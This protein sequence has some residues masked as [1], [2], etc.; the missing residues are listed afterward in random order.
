MLDRKKRGLAIPGQPPRKLNGLAF[1]LTLQAPARMPIRCRQLGIARFP[2]HG[3]V[4]NVLVT[5]LTTQS[6]F[7]A[8]IPFSPAQ[9]ATVRDIGS[10]LHLGET[11][12]ALKSGEI[13]GSHSD[14][15]AKENNNDGKQSCGP[16]ASATE[17]RQRQ[18]RTQAAA[19][20]AGSFCGN[21]R[22][23]YQ[24][25]VGATRKQYPGTICRAEA[26]GLWLVVPAYPLGRPGPQVIFI[27]AIPDEKRARIVSWAFWRNFKFCAWIGPRHTNYP[28]GSVCA[29]PPNQG[30][31]G[32]GD[33]FVHYLDRSCEWC[34]RHIHLWSEKYWP[35][36]QSGMGPHYQLAEG[37]PQELCFCRS[38]KEYYA[39][40]RNEDAVNACDRSRDN[41][42]TLT[43]GIE[44]GGQQPHRQIVEYVLGRRAKFPK[45]AAVHPELVAISG[46]S[47]NPLGGS[48]NP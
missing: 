29:F 34:L 28:D 30:F 8:S 5:S 48:E 4:E 36:P 2:R 31:W 10:S 46:R 27:C 17:P 12:F 41:F 9:L 3:G 7:L 24:A 18:G 40:C 33:R 39:C 26:S 16:R 32:E 19:Y 20:S 25:Q 43:G 14:K 38:G 11:V 13:V 37:L 1:G 21:R 22:E 23:Y 35:G 45:M 6:E 42:L 47:W 15:K 44:V